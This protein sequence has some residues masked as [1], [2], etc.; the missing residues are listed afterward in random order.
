MARAPAL[1][2][3]GRLFDSDYL[4]KKPGFT[5]GF[6]CWEIVGVS[7]GKA[8]AFY[9][10]AHPQTPRSVAASFRWLWAAAEAAERF[11]LNRILDGDYRRYNGFVFLYVFCAQLN[12]NIHIK[13]LRAITLSLKRRHLSIF[14]NRLRLLFLSLWFIYI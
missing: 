8:A 1:Q 13:R 11:A 9:T 6:F 12:L 2:A 10:G 3:G 7:S 4:H 14:N 5:P